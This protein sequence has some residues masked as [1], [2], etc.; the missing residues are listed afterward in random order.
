MFLWRTRENYLLI[1]TTLLSRSTDLTGLGKQC[2]PDQ[3]APEG[4]ESTLFAIAS[5][6]L[7]L[8]AV[9]LNHDT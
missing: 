5:V 7:E 8:T 3:T 4:S 6:F 9:W 2:T 1:I